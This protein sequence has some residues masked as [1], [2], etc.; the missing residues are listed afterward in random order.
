[1]VTQRPTRYYST[2]QEKSIAKLVRGKV[3]A[4]SGAA[5]FCA[6]DVQTH[7][8]LY[9]CKTVTQEKRSYSVKQDVLNKIQKEA[10]SMGRRHAVLVFNF[11]PNGEPY[12]VL[13]KKHYLELIQNI[14]ND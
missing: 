8:T 11:K 10:F 2:K 6:G 4:N 7:D 5:P 9:E 1:M 3:N 14:Q 12:F 13:T